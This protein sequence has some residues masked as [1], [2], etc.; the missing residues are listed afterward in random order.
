MKNKH[1]HMK[2]LFVFVISIFIFSCKKTSEQPLP[3]NLNGQWKLTEIFD[4]YL[5]GGGFKWSKVSSADSHILT[6]SADGQFSRKENE[7]GN[8]IECTGNY[9][10]DSSQL[11][12]TTDCN[13][14]PETMKVSELTTKSLII[15]RM[16]IEG[17]IRFKYIAVF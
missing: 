1:R 11:E 8:F 9:E 6:F 14:F 17:V 7:S 16:G 2:F 10:F 13:T 4:G 15:D 12:I 5:N 3:G